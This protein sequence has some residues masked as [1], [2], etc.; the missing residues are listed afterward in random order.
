MSIE[1]SEQGDAESPA[2]EAERVA[3]T[4]VQVRA[5]VAKR[6]NLADFQNS[7]PALLELAVVNETAQEI[8]DLTLAVSSEPAFVKPKS[9]TLDAVGPGQTFHVAQLDLQLDGAHLSRLTEAEPATFVFELR[10][11]QLPGELIASCEQH[12]ELLARNQWGGITYMPEMVAAFVQPND[13]AVDRVLKAAAL[14][15]EAAGRSGSIDGYT[16][17]AKRA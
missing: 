12:I 6:I 8:R 15:L 7:V 2:P 11:H 10:S 9:W 1:G 3:T 16:H 5:A 13:P 14:A 4:A 17:G